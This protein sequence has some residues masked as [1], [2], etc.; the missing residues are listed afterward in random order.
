MNMSLPSSL[1][2]LSHLLPAKTLPLW[3]HHL[4]FKTKE[5][6]EDSQ[7][8]QGD[9][10]SE[11]GSDGKMHLSDTDVCACH[12]FTAPPLVYP[13]ALGVLLMWPHTRL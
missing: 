10:A 4:S 6:C 13:R 9:T 3:Y 2:T 5:A 1:H 7:F 11:Q 8:V 12:H